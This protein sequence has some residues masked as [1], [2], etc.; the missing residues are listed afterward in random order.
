M[1]ITKIEIFHV[2]TRPQSGQRPILVKVS[3]D[4]GIYGLGEA[5]IAYGVGGSAAAGIL[6]DYAALLIG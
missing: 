2:H 3:T 5:G 1:K 6:K 4:E